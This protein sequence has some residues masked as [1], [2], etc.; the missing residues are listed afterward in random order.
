VTR[1]QMASYIAQMIEFVIGEAIPVG[2]GFAPAFDDTDGVHETSINKLATL[3][4][5]MGRADGTYGPTA[6]PGS[7]RSTS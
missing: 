7:P 5:V 1:G 4:V 2:D 3:G 6:A